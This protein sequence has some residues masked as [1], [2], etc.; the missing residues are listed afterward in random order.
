MK[1]YIDI[2]VYEACLKRLDYIFKEF[3]NIYVAFSGGKDSTLLLN[4][5]IKYIKDNNLN[6]KIGVYHLDYECQYQK[7]IEFVEFMEKKYK[8]YIDLYH[9]CLPLKAQN[10][11]SM[12]KGY[13]KPWNLKEKNLWVRKLPINSINIYN[14]NFGEYYNENMTD[15]DFNISFAGW[16][17]SQNK[18][19]G[20]TIGLIGIRADE[21]F[22]RYLRIRNGFRKYEDKNYIYELKNG[23]YNAYP[24][25]DWTVRD[26]WV[27]NAKFN[28]DYNP[29]YDLFYQAGVPIDKMRVAS[30]FNDC[31]S[32]ALKLYKIIDPNMWGKMISRVNGVNFAGIYGGTTVMGWKS[33]TKPENFTWQEYLRF[34][35]STLDEKTRFNYESRFATSIRFWKEKGGVLD[36]KTI[37]QLRETGVKFTNRG[38]ISKKSNK[39][40]IVFDEYPDDVNVDNFQTVPSFK[41]MCICILKNDWYCK[42]MGFTPTKNDQSQ[43]KS[44]LE[45]YK[46]L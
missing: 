43:R 9:I 32:S 45:K 20:K 40:L 2:N 23:S 26:V 18:N 8:N 34:L 4:M 5:A 3:K 38:K 1:E 33:I 19:N 37:Q 29:I 17:A 27:A 12:N 30:P 35:L 31:A 10:A 13:W 22:S 7:T 21:S 41:R 16:Y 11:I 36:D 46:N 28:F 14:H 44:A 25:Y 39:D 15:Y 42:Y 6:R 24:L